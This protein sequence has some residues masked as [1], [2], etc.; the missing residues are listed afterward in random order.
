MHGYIRFIYIRCLCHQIYLESFASNNDWLQGCIKPVA[1]TT[2]T[3]CQDLTHLFA[4]NIVLV[5]LTVADAGGQTISLGFA[6]QGFEFLSCPNEIALFLVVVVPASDWVVVVCLA[7]LL[8]G[9]LAQRTL[10]LFH[11]F[12]VIPQVPVTI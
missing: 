12:V 11:A 4:D 8:Y 10:F 9:E 5:A 7:V 3:C 6:L 2:T 1:M